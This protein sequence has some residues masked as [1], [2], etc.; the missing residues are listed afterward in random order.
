MKKIETMTTM[1]TIETTVPNIKICIKATIAT[2]NSL[3]NPI[4]LVISP[5][6]FASIA[7]WMKN[8]ATMTSSNSLS[9]QRKTHKIMMM[10]K[11][12]KSPTMNKTQCHQHCLRTQK[13]A[14]AVMIKRKTKILLHW[15]HCPQ[16]DQWQ[17]EREILLQNSLW[18]WLCGWHHFQRRPPKRHQA[19]H[20]EINRQCEH[21][22]W[23]AQMQTTH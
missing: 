21:R 1:A 6:C 20:S 17:Q 14:S 11:R 19:F 12:P 18:F 2:V 9:C 22:W 10:K 13:V 8:T 7:A 15:S 3:Q 4:N 5:I 16:Q 23:N